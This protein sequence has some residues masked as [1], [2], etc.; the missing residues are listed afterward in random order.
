VPIRRRTDPAAGDAAL[1]TW[2]QDPEAATRTVLAPAVRHTLELVAEENP[3]HAVEL[4]VVE[5]DPATWLAL[6]VGDLSWAD[7]VEAGRVSASGERSD[8]SELF[9]LPG[10]R[11]TVRAARER[12]GDGAAAAETD[13]TGGAAS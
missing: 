13:P 9:P 8:L 1:V 2:A 6:A 11:R 5:T 10:P 3:G 7:A 4:R 12:A